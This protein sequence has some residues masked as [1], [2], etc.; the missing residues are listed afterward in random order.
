VLEQGF[1]ESFVSSV[2]A[3]S[4]PV[5]AA[6]STPA[7]AALLDVKMSTVTAETS[8]AASDLATQLDPNDVRNIPAR[9]MML[10][11]Y[12]LP[13]GEV[14]DKFYLASIDAYSNSVSGTIINNSKPYADYTMRAQGALPQGGSPQGPQGTTG[15]I[16]KTFRFLTTA[17]A[18]GP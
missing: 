8:R 17:T 2:L 12:T 1:T 7:A 10:E 18:P 9:G 6:E 3:N 15:F 4:A 5:F 13:S 11:N 16:L 14:V